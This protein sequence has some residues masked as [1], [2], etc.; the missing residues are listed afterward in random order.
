MKKSFLTFILMSLLGTSLFAKEMEPVDVYNLMVKTLDGAWKLSPASEQIGT[1]EAYKNKYV[2][3][4]MDTNR[5]AIAY[6]KV[7]F[8]SSLEEDLLPNTG[9]EMITM[10]HCDDFVDCNA[11]LATHYCTKMNQPEFVLNTKKTSKEKIVFDCNMK[12]K[13]CNSNEDHVHTI[14]MEISN[15]GN[16]LK[17]SYLGWTDQK[18]N[19]K[20]S[21]YHFDKK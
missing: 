18:P 20:N 3:P 16:H 4:L 7:G 2:F 17:M 8:G 21:I 9:K 1:Q 15:N 13:L 6:K 10:Y 14:I 11:L 19:K 5:T 12:T